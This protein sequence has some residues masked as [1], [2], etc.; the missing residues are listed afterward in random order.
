MEV[1]LAWCLIYAVAK[2][3][4]ETTL[5]VRDL[6]RGR[7]V[8]VDPAR[9]DTATGP[10]GERPVRPS[11]TGRTLGTIC[12]LAV[13][14]FR[15]GWRQGWDGGRTAR[16]TGEPWRPWRQPRPG[17][18]PRG[19]TGPEVGFDPPGTSY[20]P[21]PGPQPGPHA[22]PNPRPTPGPRPGA[23]GGGAPTAGGPTPPGP[24]P[25]PGTPPDP[26][27][28]SP[29]ASADADDDIVDGAPRCWAELLD[30]DR[31]KV[32]EA[33]QR[34]YGR[35]WPN[36][37]IDQ[38]LA[39]VADYLNHVYG[40]ALTPDDV[41]A[42]QREHPDDRTFYAPRYAGPASVPTCWS[43]MDILDRLYTVQRSS[44]LWDRRPWAELTEAERAWAVGD[45]IAERYGPR[46]SVAEVLAAERAQPTPTDWGL[47]DD[48]E[49][50][51]D[52]TD[53]DPA[54]AGPVHAP[55]AI[56]AGPTPQGDH[57]VTTSGETNT[58]R[59]AVAYYTQ[60]QGHALNDIASQIELSRSSMTGAQLADPQVISAVATAEEAARTL[61]AA[62]GLAVTALSRH[63]VMEEAVAAT[64]GA[65]NT[66]FYRQG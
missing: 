24:P 8:N 12:R 30:D 5:N 43:D 54:P 4:Q 6:L 20:G 23:P 58:F 31:E 46:L 45:V 48:M 61:A 25:G 56:A 29:A 14:S 19:A 10:A 38:C 53:S 1:I 39:A 50:V 35:H 37:T 27:G 21:N 26:A 18:V 11:F 22:G 13:A 51:P 52:P 41:A 7:T 9:P 17:R 66:D 42:A 62:S 65:A 49:Y 44:D 16:Q 34:R 32:I 60:L 3:L 36:L 63:T 15:A 40:T 2:S 47:D 55:A 59:S 64:P 28:P 33:A 57:M